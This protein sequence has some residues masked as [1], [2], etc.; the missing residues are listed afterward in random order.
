L[1]VIEYDGLPI[2]GRDW[3]GEFDIFSSKF[4]INVLAYEDISKLFPSVFKD[5]LGCYKLKE[6]EL[7]VKYDVVPIFCKPRALPF[8]LKDKVSEELD[9]LV[10]E[11]IL[12]AV[13][14]SEWGTPIVPVIKA[15]GSIRLC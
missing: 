13:E 5:T 6:F 7:Y 14:T 15:D 12:V 1:Y 8:A 10:K 4:D 3:L 2:I 9:R 11:D